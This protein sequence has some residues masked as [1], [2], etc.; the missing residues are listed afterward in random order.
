MES[1]TTS[2]GGARP[3]RPKPPRRS[4]GSHATPPATR[5]RPSARPR[6]GPDKKPAPARAAAAGEVTGILDSI[7]RIVRMLRVTSRAVEKHF[8][9]SGAQ[10]FVLHALAKGPALSL[11][12]VAERTRTHQSSV[13]VVEQRREERGLVARAPVPGDARRIGLSLTPAAEQ[14]ILATPDAPSERLI[15]ALER[16]PSKV[17]ARLADGLERLV[18]EVGAA[19]QPASMLFE[20]DSAAAGAGANAAAAAPP[21]T[22]ATP[23]AP[24]AARAAPDGQG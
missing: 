7:R 20:E 9:L 16:M 21:S 15:S 18:N 11:N 10:L 19:D 1:H 5:K 13:S 8:G 14:M 12:E 4:K 3:R 22:P 6:A 23:A 24:P 2:S 17:R